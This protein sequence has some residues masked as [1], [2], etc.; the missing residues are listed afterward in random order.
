MRTISKTSVRAI[1]AVSLVAFIA[2]G[3]CTPQYQNHGYI[4]P[5]EDLD[6]IKVGTDTRESVAEKIGV[7]TSAGVLDN[8]GYY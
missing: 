6:E 3:A 1:Q 7:P 5:Q 4:P 8:S 2:L